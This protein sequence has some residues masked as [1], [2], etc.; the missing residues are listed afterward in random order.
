M[1]IYSKTQLLILTYFEKLF[2]QHILDV[3]TEPPCH[4][5]EHMGQDSVRYPVTGTGEIYSNN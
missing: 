2:L 3:M 1:V 4:V 5:Q